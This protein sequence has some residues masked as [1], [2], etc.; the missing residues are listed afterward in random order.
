MVVSVQY[1]PF[2]LEMMGFSK[3]TKAA[4]CE[5]M[6]MNILENFKLFRFVQVDCR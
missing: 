6:N 5:V 3:S 1:P 4:R 2:T